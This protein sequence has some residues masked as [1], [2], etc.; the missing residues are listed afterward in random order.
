M[1]KLKNVNGGLQYLYALPPSPE[2][3]DKLQLEP[4][5]PVCI[6]ALVLTQN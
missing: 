1:V 2:L 6:V 4:P 5:A 3:F